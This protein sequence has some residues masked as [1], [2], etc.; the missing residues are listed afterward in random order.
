[1]RSVEYN[2]QDIGR[3]Q[4]ELERV[5]IL[6]QIRLLRGIKLPIVISGKTPADAVIKHSNE[7]LR[8]YQCGKCNL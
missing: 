4:P 6:F 3:D 1:M 2:M 7:W 8:P 5:V